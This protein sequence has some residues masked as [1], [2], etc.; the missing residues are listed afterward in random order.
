[1]YSMALQHRYFHFNLHKNGYYRICKT[2]YFVTCSRSPLTHVRDYEPE[3]L[4]PASVIQW[5]WTKCSSRC[6]PGTLTTADQTMAN[7]SNLLRNLWWSIVIFSLVT[8][9]VSTFV[10]LSCKV[11]ETQHC[12]CNTHQFV[13]ASK[14]NQCYLVKYCRQI[15]YCKDYH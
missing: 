6:V 7:W 1:M 5:P 14:N 3:A 13:P 4:P 8:T 11:H 12:Y 10:F 9:H 15:K 2:H